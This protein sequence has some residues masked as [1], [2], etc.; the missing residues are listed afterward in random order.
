MKYEG[1]TGPPFSTTQ[2]LSKFTVQEY[3]YAAF[4]VSFFE[5]KLN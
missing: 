1:G 5:F 2:S 4:E 3:G